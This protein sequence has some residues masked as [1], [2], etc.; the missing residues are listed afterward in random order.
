M[1][2]LAASPLPRLALIGISGYG[3]IHL[4]LA[5]EWRDRGEAVIVAATV[6]NA[7]EEVEEVAGLRA[8]GC[9]IF[10]DYEQMLAAHAGRI[11][12]CMIPTGIHWH[13]RM[14]IAALRAGANVLVEKP[15]SG[16]MS[17]VA[18]VRAAEHETGRFVAVGFQDYYE[19]GTAWL[20]QHLLDGAIG[21]VRSVRFLGLWPRPRSYFLRNEWAGRLLHQGRPVF[22]SPLSNAFAHFVMLS[23]YFAGET[24]TQP[25]AARL[26]NA[27]LFRAH[28][29]ETFDTAVARLETGAGVKLWFGVSHACHTLREPEIVIEGSTGSAGWRYEREAWWRGPD[30]ELHRRALPDA[31]GARHDMM[32]AAVARLR[33]EQVAVCTPEI[34]ARHTQVI[35]ALH[36]QVPVHVWA[37]EDLHWTQAVSPEGAIPWVEGMDE[38][39]HRAYRDGVSLAEANFFPP[40]RVTA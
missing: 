32:V 1:S 20:K 17:E 16:V 22:D 36:S 38:A 15:L 29:I 8:G 10:A 19:P 30:G 40:Y 12:L 34:A 27:E 4:N 2:N 37:A 33:D 3:R 31:F 28:A 14:T 21:R 6:I 39:L 7:E 25:A 13:A 23:L 35:E 24:L 26:T 5:K 9:E 11:D 18:A